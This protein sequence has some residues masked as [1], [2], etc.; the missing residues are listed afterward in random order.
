MSSEDEI[1]RK[2][3]LQITQKKK[4]PAGRKARI[5]SLI[6]GLPA[7]NFPMTEKQGA[8]V[9]PQAQPIAKAANISVAK[10]IS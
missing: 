8:W 5:R 9:Q 6:C 3:I 7:G 4:M 10:Q 2:K 1:L